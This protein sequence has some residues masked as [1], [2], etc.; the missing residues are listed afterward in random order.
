MFFKF[1]FLFVIYV[2]ITIYFYIISC[3]SDKL[4]YYISFLFLHFL[5]KLLWFRTIFLKRKLRNKNSYV[6]TLFIIFLYFDV[7][8]WHINLLYIPLL[9]FIHLFLF[10]YE[11]ILY[12]F[13]LF[14][15]SVNYIIR[16]HLFLHYNML[17][18]QIKLLN[19]LFIL[20][21]YFDVSIT[22][23][24]YHDIHLFIRL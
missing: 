16:I 23:Y 24:I 14:F 11:I 6:S 10:F 7:L 17:F 4:T 19:S 20:F 21:L 15:L 8:F 2:V 3:Y 22:Y 13:E 12:D 1:Y 18:W 9:I 5:M